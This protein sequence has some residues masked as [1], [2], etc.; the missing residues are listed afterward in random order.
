MIGSA[1]SELEAEVVRTLERDGLYATSLAAFSLPGTAEMFNAG[2]EIAAALANG[3]GRPRSGSRKSTSPEITGSEAY[4]PLFK[5][6]THVSL[7]RIV[8]AYLGLPAAYD[9]P[10]VAYT[11]ADGRQ[12]GTRLWHRDREDRRMLKIAIY[13]TDVTDSGGPLQCLKP[14]VYEGR[15]DQGFRYP[16]RTHA[17]LE[18]QV[19]RSIVDDDITSF[20]RPAGTV[21]FVD[22]ARLYHRGKPAVDADRRTIFHTYFS[23]SPR[24]PF[25]CE[26]SDLSRADLARF[27][28]E[29]TDA[30]Q[31][32]AVSWR[33]TVGWLRLVPKSAV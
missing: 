18:R 3:F 28:Q 23:L 1:L 12:A 31:R 5:W 13:L 11:P 19:G 32:D 20:K 16:V 6:G 10:K 14:D 7:L 22:T 24:H 4:R 29:L 33:D 25:F 26:R 8:E 9:G 30:T 15:L 17:Q 27:A 2:T 21:I